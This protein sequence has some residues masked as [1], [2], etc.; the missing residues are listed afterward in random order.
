MAGLRDLRMA[1]KLVCS[2]AA[3]ALLACVVGAA[4]F[5]GLHTGQSTLHTITV[6]SSP[7]LVHLLRTDDDVHAAL[8][9]TRGVLI[10]NDPGVTNLLLAQGATARKN[11]LIEFRKFQ[12]LAIHDSGSD[13]VLIAKAEKQLQAWIAIDANVGPSFLE[14]QVTAMTTALGPDQDALTALSTQLDALLARTQK[15]LDS[16]SQQADS[17]ANHAIDVLAGVLAGAV[18][19][20]LALGLLIARSMSRPL[21]EVKRAATS[22]AHTCIAQLADGI[23]ALAMGD[24]TF[25]AA[26]EPLVPTY[27][28]ND[29]IG[30]T[31]E[32]V[33]TIIARAQ[34]AIEAYETAR[35][36]LA[37]LIGQVAST[38]ALVHAESATLAHSIAQIGQAS[39]QISHA[40]EE[41]AHGT[42]DQS[43]ES[44]E[45]SSHMQVL[46]SVVE[47]VAGG[48][49]AQRTAVGQTHQAIG[50][51]RVALSDTTL[52]VSAVTGAAD[53][54]AAT[55]RQGSAAVADTIHSVDDVRSAV[56]QSVDQVAALG[57]RSREIGAI[58]EAIGD[59]AA[60]TNLLALNA[61]IEA[62]RAGEHGKGFTVVAAEVRKLAERAS[63]ETKQVTQRVLAI[64]QQVADV[65]SAM[66]VGST[67]VER[68]ASLGRQAG[69]ALAGILGVVD[70]TNAQAAAITAAIERMTASVTAVSDASDHVARIESQTADAAEHMR[71][72]A[73]LVQ[74][75]IDSIASVSEESAAG[76][77]EVSA[78]TE[79]QSASVEQVS[80]GAGQLAVLADRLQELMQR[81]KLQP[82]DAL[83]ETGISRAGASAAKRSA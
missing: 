34:T 41:V 65:V 69:N 25:A 45:A 73:Q 82:T 12:S 38:S 61:A 2:F 15:S 76:A 56:A 53:R 36:D 32:A 47:Q 83:G 23:S 26:A 8:S 3:V 11:A 60:Q 80:A 55:V 24:L 81:F 16:S 68:S 46:A 52:S 37:H 63:S 49:A 71:E 79:Q 78:S 14:N 42:S 66:A 13:T 9:A 67:A 4:G 7:S 21:G 74:R 18:L 33:R 1:T 58:V 20:A 22:V 57:A 29:E 28:A 27:T 43:R 5:V 59:I 10:A 62:A 6:T 72:V 35:A 17:N 75:A 51:L 64:Q 31:A 54:A 40:I 19:V 77:Q 39:S 50:D 48:A 44:A 30:E 70:E